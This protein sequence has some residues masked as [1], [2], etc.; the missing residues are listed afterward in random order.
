[1]IH[2]PDIRRVAQILLD[3]HGRSARELAVLRADQLLQQCDI[4][5]AMVWDLIL[6]AIEELQ[7]GRRVRGAVN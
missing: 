1:M 6:S 2:D 4:S 5:G 7:R 3:K